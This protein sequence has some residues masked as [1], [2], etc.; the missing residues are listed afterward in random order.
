MLP[1]LWAMGKQKVFVFMVVLLCQL[2]SEAA[3]NTF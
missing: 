1:V 2:K 3:S